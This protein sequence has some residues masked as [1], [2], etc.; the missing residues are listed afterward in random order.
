MLTKEISIPEGVNVDVV[1]NIVKVSG[2]KGQVERQF[3]LNRDMKIEKADN[4][5]KVTSESEVRNA[6]ALVGTIIAHIRN[7][8]TG[9]TTGYTYRLRTVYAHFPITVKVEGSKV[10]VQNFL[11]ERTPR[12]AN[13]LNSVQVKIEGPDLIVSGVDVEKVSQTSANIEQATRIVGYDKKIFQD[14]IFLVSREG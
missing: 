3:Q 4:K 2:T 9:V 13:I 5:V 11:G 7:M 6:R 1:G 10:L 8:F 14:G 12:I